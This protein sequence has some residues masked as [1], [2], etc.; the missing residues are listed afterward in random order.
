MRFAGL[1][2][3]PGRADVIDLTD[4]RRAL[5]RTGPLPMP[6]RKGGNMLTWLKILKA[7]I[8]IAVAIVELL[9]EDL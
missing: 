6:K 5:H 7:A 8:V 1:P 9:S 3:Q 2:F 4:P